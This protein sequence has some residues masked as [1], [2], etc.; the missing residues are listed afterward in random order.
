MIFYPFIFPSFLNKCTKKGKP[1]NAVINPT[2]I[3][4]GDNIVFAIMSEDNKII[5]PINEA[6]GIKYF[7]FGDTC[8]CHFG[9]LDDS[10]N[11]R[12]TILR[13]YIN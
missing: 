12:Q 6:W 8:K 5:A 2:G 10:A 3:S 1:K 13:L 11:S 7:G 4:V 9:E